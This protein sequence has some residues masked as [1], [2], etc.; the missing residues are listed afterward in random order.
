MKPHT[1]RIW[2]ILSVVVCLTVITER[3]FCRTPSG[4]MDDQLKPAPS[5]A[6]RSDA[7]VKVTSQAEMPNAQGQRLVTIR[8]T[9]DQGWYIYGNPVGNSEMEGSETTVSVVG[10]RGKLLDVRYPKGKMRKEKLLDN[11]VE[12]QIYEGTVTIQAVVEPPPG[13]GGME[14]AVKFGACSQ[15]GSCLQPA[16]VKIAVK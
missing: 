14:L 4:G 2:M 9:I 7:V 10:G 3:L 6:K 1:H 11:E 12:Y 13:G 16:T 8:L 5:Q 15:R